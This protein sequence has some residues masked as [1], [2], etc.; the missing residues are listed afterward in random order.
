MAAI[1]GIEFL[2]PCV[3]VNE[4]LKLYKK[5]AI[6]KSLLGKL[7]AELSHSVVN[8]QLIQILTLGESV[9]STRIEGTQVTFADMIDEATKKNKSNEVVEVENY[10]K[11]L[12]IG[13]DLIREGNPISTR[14]I[15]QLHKVLM[16]QDARGTTAN[17]GEFRKIQ[18]FI[19]PNN[20]M[21]DA[22]YIPVNANEI[23][24][25]MSNLEHYIN[26]TP[27][28]SLSKNLEEPLILLDQNSDILIK[29][30]IIHAQFESIHPFLDGNG[31]MGRILIVLS[32][33]QD[34][35]IDKPVFFV[36]DEL[37]K[38]RLRYYNLLNGVR[39]KSPDWFAWIDFFLDACER[40][41]RN[42]LQKLEG[43]TDLAKEGLEIINKKAIINQVWLN[44]FFKPYL[45][46]KE[47]S[48]RLR[49]SV[50]T[51]RKCL[52]ELVELGLLDVDKSKTKNKIYVNY[53]LIR[54]L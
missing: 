26:S 21:E 23:D 31:R 15:K 49:I 28:R 25:F 2:P 39:G 20:K 9:Q 12:S 7:N 53:D 4:A 14:L 37:E 6:I 54:L 42:M 8:S 33:M 10:M 45:T 48:E 46:V 18:N 3:S 34:G 19:G 32:T 16:G 27:H 40:M 5:V 35:L 24:D 36:S 47:T 44:S 17:A 30:A 43:I 50:A 1:K 38:E 22:T 11:A 52:N 41:S 29:T 51:A 13:I